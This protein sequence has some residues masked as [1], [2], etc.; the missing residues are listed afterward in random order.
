[1]NWKEVSQSTSPF[2]KGDAVIVSDAA[3]IYSGV[4][5]D[6]STETRV[7]LVLSIQNAR[8]QMDLDNDDNLVETLLP[9]GSIEWI[10]EQDL[11]K[12]NS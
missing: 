1:M 11:V 8:Q 10:W 4:K 2:M 12:L 6:G 5:Q 3:L 7:G 9:D